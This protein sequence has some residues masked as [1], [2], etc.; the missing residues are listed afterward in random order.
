MRGICA[1]SLNMFKRWS[2]RIKLM[3]LNWHMDDSN[4]TW[5]AC[6]SS[7]TTMS[8]SHL[9]RAHTTMDLRR[10][11]K[12]TRNKMVFLRKRTLPN[13]KWTWTHIWSRTKLMS[14]L[15]TQELLKMLRS[16]KNYNLLSSSHK[17]KKSQC[18]KAQA[19]TKLWTYLPNQTIK[20]WSLTL[21]HNSS[22]Q[23]RTTH[24]TNPKLTR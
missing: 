11:W 21:S 17:V 2:F 12:R 22:S 9:K 24:T 23:P 8:E 3:F 5:S 4:T 7:L 6:S 18:L 16:I 10:G 19:L 15:L 1:S 13:S 20:V 14:D